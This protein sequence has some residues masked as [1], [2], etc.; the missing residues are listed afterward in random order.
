MNVLTSSQLETKM[1]ERSFMSRTAT[2][3]KRPVDLPR[4]AVVDKRDLRQKLKAL[5]DGAVR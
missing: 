5:V 4:P 3:Q 1:N 2:V